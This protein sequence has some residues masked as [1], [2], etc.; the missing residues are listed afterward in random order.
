MIMT[1]IYKQKKGL[2]GRLFYH[3]VKYA[4]TSPYV[5]KII[6]TTQSERKKYQ[7]IFG[8][9]EAMFGFAKCGAIEYQPEEFDDNELKKKNY[10]FSTGRSNRDYSFL[11]Q[12]IEGTEYQLIIACDTLDAETH[13]NI[14]VRKN[15]FGQE[16][17]RYMRNAKAVVIALDDDTIAAG[18]LVLLHAMNMGVPVIITR[19]NG[20]TDDYVIDHYNGLI[21]EKTKE[22]L[23]EA[24]ALI[25]HD[26]D[27]YDQLCENGQK[28]FVND[29]TYYAMGK[30]IGGIL[31]CHLETEEMD[32][33]NELISVIVPVYNVSRYIDRCMTSL[34]K[35]TYENIEIIL[36]DDGSPD[37]CGFKCDQ[38]A[39]TDSRVYVIH[40]KNAGLGMAR[41]SGLDIAKGKYVAFIDSDD[42]VDE[43]MFERLYDRLKHEKADTC[44]CRYYDRTSDGQNLLAR[45]VYK[46]SLYCEEEVW[47][48]LLGMIGNLPE[49]AGDVAI[50]MSVWKGLYANAIIQEQGIRF[51][52]ER[53]YISEDIIF[54]MQY[55]LYAQRIAIEE[56]PLYYYC[57]NGT[58]LTKSYKVNRFKME[59]IL[60]KKEM[61]ELDQIFEPDIYR[62]R[63]YKSYLG[64]V[65]RCIAQE[66]FM[67]PE[68]QVARKNIRRICSSPIVQDVIKKYDSHN[69]H[70]TKQLTNRLIQHK[71]TSAL[72]IVFRLKG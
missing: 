6:L 23:L 8:V 33:E 52:S 25:F 43:Q 67:N 48:L 54:H 66:V 2:A 49:E 16:M 63:L 46:K 38:Y 72:I 9:D 62:Q 14:E 20:V 70:W 17:L 39:R 58:S 22:A 21:I 10:L 41:N 35:Q 34:L 29:Y 55:L 44:F 57:D 36:V 59:N 19:S 71:W 42:Y 7:E 61:K 31:K 60:L 15:T 13:D 24:L 28:E 30:T 53:E 56:T 5:D 18:Q 68:R 27:L 1:F 40:K 64:R 3:F 65:R 37:D 4:I 50:G 69:L 45:E 51:P 32:M 11:M 47:E 26:D 12:A